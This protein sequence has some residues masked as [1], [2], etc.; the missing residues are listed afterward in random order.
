MST[1]YLVPTPIGNLQDMTFR[2]IEVLK[3]ADLILAEDTRTSGKLLKHFQIDTPMRA[4]HMHNEHKLADEMVEQVASGR[5]LAV[6]TDA[7]TPGISDPGYLIAQKAIEKNLEVTLKKLSFDLKKT[8]DEAEL[9]ESRYIENTQRALEFGIF[10][11]PSFS[12]NDDIFWGDDRLED[13]IYLI[14]KK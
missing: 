3:E 14:S 10:G 4:Y 5:T 1:L 2:A 9:M 7:G 11:V 6:I 12:F 8:I 13:A